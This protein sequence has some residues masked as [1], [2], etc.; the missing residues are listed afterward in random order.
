METL[1]AIDAILRVGGLEVEQS[2]LLVPGR[3]LVVPPAP[4]VPV[5]VPP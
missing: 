4:K 3:R 1:R 5:S 2:V